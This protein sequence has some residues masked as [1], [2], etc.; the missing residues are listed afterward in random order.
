[1]RAT[2]SRKAI[3]LWLCLVALVFL[4]LYVLSLVW[5]PEFRYSVHLSKNEAAQDEGLPMTDTDGDGLSDIDECF[6]YSTNYTDPDTDGDGMPDGWEIRH[7]RKVWV[8]ENE[9]GFWALDA[10]NV[11][12]AH[13]DADNDGL[14]NLMEYRHSTDPN[15][16]DTDNDTLWDWWEVY[17]GLDPTNATDAEAD[18][19]GDGLSNHDEFLHGTNPRS[20]D[21]D[22]DGLSDYAELYSY[23]TDPTDSDTDDD[24]MPDGWE[25]GYGLNPMNRSDAFGDGDADGLINLKEFKSGASPVDPDT[26]DDGILDGWEVKHGLDP[27]DPSD[28]FDDLDGD[29]LNNYDEYLNDTDPRNP[30]TDNDKLTDYEELKVYGTNPALPDTD[31]DNLTDYAEV[32]TYFEGSLVDWNDDGHIENYTNPNSRDSDADG[33]DDHAELYIYDTHP[34]N[35]DYDM[36]GLSD[37]DEVYVYHTNPNDI[38]TDDD[39][40]LDGEEVH[41]FRYDDDYVLRPQSPTDPLLPDT[42]GDT[43]PDGWEY[44]HGRWLGTCWSLDPTNPTDKY[45]DPDDDGL[46]NYKE[47]KPWGSKPHNPDTDDDGMPDGWEARYAKQVNESTGYWD[48]D[49]RRAEDAWTDADND[50]VCNLKEYLYRTNPQNTDTDGDKMV[51]SWEIYYGDH[52]GDGLPNWFEELYG[53]PSNWTEYWSVVYGWAQFDG[54][55]PWVNDTDGNNL[56]DADEDADGDGYSN[57]DEYTNCTDPNDAGSQPVSRGASAHA[58]LFVILSRLTR[59]RQGI[60]RWDSTLRQ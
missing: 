47:C 24:H 10:N 58:S 43:M 19:D 28:A 18:L 25:L 34:L 57:M 23:L 22:N 4:G 42:D 36:D 13:K 11:S 16:P 51:D 38:D 2:V 46:A 6:A 12:D 45:E 29:E 33:V 59:E 54:F 56:S 35:D 15:A 50:T 1:M 27:V 53:L 9:T 17:Y 20:N 52:D 41:P 32:T 39:E 44:E 5:V 31:G 49:P 48:I 14:T 21:T 26:D 8:V 40:L 30:D 60:H 7:R 3:L 55:I 37:G